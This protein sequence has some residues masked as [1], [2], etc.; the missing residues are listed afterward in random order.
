[1]ASCYVLCL[2]KESVNTAT[3][4][5]APVC[6]CACV[7][8][9]GLSDTSA[10]EISS[11]GGSGLNSDPDR[12]PDFEKPWAIMFQ[13]CKSTPTEVSWQNKISKNFVLTFAWISGWF[14][15]R[16]RFRF[17]V[18]LPAISAP[19]GLH[20]VLFVLIS[21]VKLTRISSLLFLPAVAI[22]L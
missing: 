9:G 15:C 14:P 12:S 22:S 8:S 18:F 3:L 20:K 1:M 19:H 17:V 21:N 5:H 16:C 2:T 4:V 7:P 11:G 6:V 10:L 13:L